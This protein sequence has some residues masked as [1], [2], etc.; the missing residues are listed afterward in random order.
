MQAL[1]KILQFIKSLFSRIPKELRIA[2]HIGVVVTENLKKLVDS[3]ATDIL[4]AIIPG[5]IDDRMK[6]WLRA[7]LP[8]ILLQLK[9]ADNGIPHKSDG[10]I[11]KCGIETLNLLNSN[12]RDIFLHNISILTAQAASYNKLKWQDGVYLVEWYYQKKYKPITQ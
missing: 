3:P 2:I 11:I 4:T 1:S 10:E 5:D 12:I 6:L 8:I 9:L 7:R